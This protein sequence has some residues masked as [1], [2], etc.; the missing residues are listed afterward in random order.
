MRQTDYL[1]FIKR[2]IIQDVHIYHANSDTALLGHSLDFK[3][4]LSVLDIG[5]NTGGLLIYASELRPKELV[6]IDINEE[7]LKLASENLKLNG[8]EAKLLLSSLNA[9]RHEPFDV[10]V[11]NPPFLQSDGRR[12]RFREAMDQAMLPL[13]DLFKGFKR[14]IKDNGTIYMIYAAEYLED[15]IIR[16]HEAKFKIMSIRPVYDVNK[17]E[18]TR[19]IL[20]IKKGHHTKTRVLKPYLIKKGV[21]LVDL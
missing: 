21:I 10:I 20:K 15:I 6:G 13:D 16:A 19:V 14:L 17:N 5:T 8:I 4:G 12:Q 2:P 18:A 3:K 9:F 7:A 11:I 1:P